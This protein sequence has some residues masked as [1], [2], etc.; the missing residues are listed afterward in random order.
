MPY[1]DSQP[2]TWVP[3]IL[4]N[5]TVEKLRINALNNLTLSS[6]NI[7]QPLQR[8][9]I[10]LSIRK[11]QRQTKTK[12]QHS[13]HHRKDQWPMLQ[14]AHLAREA[15]DAFSFWFAAFGS[16]EGS[17]IWA[18]DCG[19]AEK[20]LNSLEAIP[21]PKPSKPPPNNNNY[22]LGSIPNFSGFESR[23]SI[24]ASIS[25]LHLLN[26]RPWWPPDVVYQKFCALVGPK[27]SAVTEKLT[28]SRMGALYYSCESGY[29]VA[30][31]H[32]NR[33]CDMSFFYRE[34]N[35]NYN[36]WK[37]IDGTT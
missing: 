3:W 7:I 21:S 23:F 2:W 13:E 26:A 17:V 1:T 29:P 33:T 36:K 27:L 25:V 22:I 31:R 20:Y 37:I 9:K 35:K 8:L 19:M 30:I 24:V 18:Q 5:M 16:K 34:I 14:I 10:Q 4:H 11:S 12:S 28:T 32:G 15:I 6:Y